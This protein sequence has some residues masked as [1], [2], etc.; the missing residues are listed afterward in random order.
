[1]RS[2]SPAAPKR[3]VPPGLVHHTGAQ[4][5]GKGTHDSLALLP[6]LRQQPVHK[7][8]LADLVHGDAIVTDES[9]FG[10]PGGS[11]LGAAGL[12]VEPEGQGGEREGN[13]DA[14]E[15]AEGAKINDCHQQEAAIWKGSSPFLGSQFLWTHPLVHASS[16][17]GFILS[18]STHFQHPQC[19]RLCFWAKIRGP[20]HL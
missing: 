16:P 11:W 18:S 12:S 14:T 15:G 17:R 5:A 6:L 20:P 9:A 8:L 1:M 19:L 10:V 7:I 3:K 2:S 13:Q 4:G